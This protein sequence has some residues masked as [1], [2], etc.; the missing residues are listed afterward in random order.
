[1]HAGEPPA[2][3]RNHPYWTMWTPTGKRAAAVSGWPP[4]TPQ[5][6]IFSLYCCPDIQ[7]GHP[8]PSTVMY[9]IINGVPLGMVQTVWSFFHS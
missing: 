5:C 1:M 8:P 3:V 9:L 2:I 7:P 6:S 4:S